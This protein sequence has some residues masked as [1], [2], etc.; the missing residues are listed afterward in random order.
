MGDAQVGSATAAVD[1]RTG[2]EY[3]YTV[4]LQCFND[5]AGAASGGHDILNHDGGFAWTDGEASAEDHFAGGRI[6]FGEQ[7]SCAEGSGD[8]M[9]DDQAADGGGNHDFYFTEMRRQLA[10]E[11]FGDRR[12]LEHQRALHVF[13]GMETTGQPEV[14]F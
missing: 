9:A 14:T 2:S 1:Y 11:F 6:A 7:E 3:L 10:P 5:V 13:V 8:F 4:G 12:V